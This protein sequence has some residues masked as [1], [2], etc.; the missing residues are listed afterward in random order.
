MENHFMKYEENSECKVNIILSVNFA[1]L[2][3][4]SDIKEIKLASCSANL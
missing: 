3:V 4:M 1:A 2:N